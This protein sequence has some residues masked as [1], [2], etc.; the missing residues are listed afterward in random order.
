MNIEYDSKPVYGDEDKYIKTKIKM[1]RDRVNTNL[2]S[3]KCLKKM[4][5]I[6]AYH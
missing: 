4:L 1:Y 3:K 5:H 2:Q 6:N